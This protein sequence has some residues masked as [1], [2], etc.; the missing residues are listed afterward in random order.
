M[1]ASALGVVLL[2]VVVL[3]AAASKPPPPGDEPIGATGPIKLKKEHVTTMPSVSNVT[4]RRAMECSA[5]ITAG[6]EV[7]ARFKA[8]RLKPG[9]AKRPS[10]A[11]LEMTLSGLCSD[12]AQ[13]M[14][15]L[16]ERDTGV[17]L[18][19]FGSGRDATT[20]EYWSI[21]NGA[22]VTELWRGVCDELMQYLDEEDLLGPLYAAP[23][24][25]AVCPGCVKSNRSAMLPVELRRA[26][27]PNA[28][29]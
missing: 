5:C 28:D 22:W 2:L 4:E 13:H 11:L 25:T 12:A 26:T 3:A 24:D 7:A 8:L 15:L 1:H 20:V 23:G 19:S 21:V 14:G 18:T 16:R 10:I 27:D 6:L 9:T 29:L 17:V